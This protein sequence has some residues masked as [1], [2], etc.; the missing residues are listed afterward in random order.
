MAHFD[1]EQQEQ[2]DAIKTWWERFGTA[3]TIASVVVAVGVAS[4]TGWRWYQAR[5]AEG[6]AVL[7][8]AIQE[9]LQTNNPTRV[10][11]AAVQLTEKYP[12]TGYA[13]LAALVAARI[14]FDGGD[15]KSARS[16][17]EWT[18]ANARQDEFKD[19]ARLR[20]A[21]V[22]LDDRDHVAALRVLDSKH[23]ASFDALFLD[24]R[25]DALTAQGDAEA[26]RNAYRSALEKFD[27][28]S[29]YRNLVQIK[30]DALGEGK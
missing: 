24:V 27:A 29:P 2:I 23:S 25:G 4:A 28:Q 1:L 15:T 9:G 21:A 30:L 17:L 5:Q 7:Y 26:A 14:D 13:A 11:E 3:V 8:L 16:R 19:V 10:R 12:G 6:A 22:M 20:L 18:I